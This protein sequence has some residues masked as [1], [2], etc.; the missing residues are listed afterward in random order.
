MD[1]FTLAARHSLNF[2]TMPYGDRVRN[3]LT[4]AFTPSDESRPAVLRQ[5]YLLVTIGARNGAP[6]RVFEEVRSPTL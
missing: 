2:L 3:M 1:E 5:G 4:P 6:K